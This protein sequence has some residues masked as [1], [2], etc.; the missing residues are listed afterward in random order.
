MIASMTRIVLGL[1]LIAL[2]GCTSTQ[3]KQG[4]RPRESALSNT[5]PCATRLHDISG[6]LLFYYATNHKLPATLDELKAVQGFE[7]VQY[8]CPVSGEPY[9]YAP[10][11]VPTPNQPGAKIVLYDPT[12]AHEGMRWAISI[13]ESGVLITKVIAVPEAYFTARGGE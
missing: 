11:G 8:T 5:D 1:A 6:V 3:P 13:T 4:V 10:A 9:V 7:E 12:P 2:V